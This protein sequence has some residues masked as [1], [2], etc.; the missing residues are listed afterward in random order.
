[1]AEQA[2]AVAQLAPLKNPLRIFEKVFES[3]C[4]LTTATNKC[5]TFIANLFVV[6]KS[7]RKPL[8]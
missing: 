7:F 6:L 5:K 1:M 3:I 8:C 2:G 4:Y